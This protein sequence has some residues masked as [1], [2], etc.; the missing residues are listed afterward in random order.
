M[1]TR[2]SSR[3]QIDVDSPS[4]RTP[5]LRTDPHI[6]KGFVVEDYII[7]RGRP[8]TV[9]Q[10][11]T[12]EALVSC[13]GIMLDED[14]AFEDIDNDATVRFS[15]SRGVELSRWNPYIDNTWGNAYV[16]L[17]QPLA[18]SDTRWIHDRVLRRG[19]IATTTD[20]VELKS[21]PHESGTMSVVFA[22][23]PTEESSSIIFDDLVIN[24]QD[25]LVEILSP[26]VTTSRRASV[27]NTPTIL[28]V[29]FNEGKCD[30]YVKPG[31]ESVSRAQL[32]ASTTG[33]IAITGR[34][35]IFSIDIWNTEI[36]VAAKLDETL[37]AVSRGKDVM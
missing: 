37:R 31:Y 9:E 11:I 14:V 10:M 12:C 34:L 15:A 3:A 19:T 4:A 35:G 26:S 22:L 1:R 18:L 2:I 32:P 33:S 17:A 30:V 28:S 20:A 27:G 5:E 8:T 25:G 6:P 21:Y 29:V 23:S 7:F 13:E 24:I 36:F 16:A